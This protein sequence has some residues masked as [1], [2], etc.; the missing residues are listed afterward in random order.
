M[1]YFKNITI[2]ITK[3]ED[4]YSIRFYHPQDKWSLG[5]IRITN[6]N[7]NLITTYM[8]INT[9]IEYIMLNHKLPTEMGD[10]I[11]MTIRNH[12]INKLEQYLKGGNDNISN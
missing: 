7:N 8:N 3:Y 10:A 9:L 4:D 5:I 6:H 12:A 11:V 2:E 1:D